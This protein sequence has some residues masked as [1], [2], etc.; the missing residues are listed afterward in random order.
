MNKSAAVAVAWQR[1]RVCQFD[2]LCRLSATREALQLSSFLLFSSLLLLLFCAVFGMDL[3]LVKYQEVSSIDRQTEI[4]IGTQRHKILHQIIIS[5]RFPSLPFP[6]HRSPPVASRF[7]QKLTLP[8]LDSCSATRLSA[9]FPM[10]FIF[11]VA[12]VSLPP[13]PKITCPLIWSI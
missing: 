6:S 9:H 3:D 7:T 8:L 1:R 13:L 10:A 11:L 5:L 4:T 12:V 2:H